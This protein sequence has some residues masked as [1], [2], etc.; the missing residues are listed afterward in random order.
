ME[1]VQDH[2]EWR[3]FV[4]AVLNLRIL[5]RE[6]KMRSFVNYNVSSNIIRLIEYRKMKW[7][8]ACVMHV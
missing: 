4:L 6:D 8:G 7:V 2:V 5:L 1:L 3:A